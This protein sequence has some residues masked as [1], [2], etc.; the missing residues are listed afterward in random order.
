MSGTLL[1]DTHVYVWA[2]SAPGRLSAAAREAILR[3]ETTLLVSAASAWEMAIKHRAG[4]W[5]EAEPLI[6]QHAE[7]VARLGAHALPI[8]AEHAIR[9]GGLP[10]SH[11]DPFDRVLAA[12]ALVLGATLVSR[13]AAFTELLGL[14]LLW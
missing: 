5:P 7:V 3:T 4:R 1:L 11:T 12:Q 6:R 9:A 14:S 8:T 10:W 13:D 2:V